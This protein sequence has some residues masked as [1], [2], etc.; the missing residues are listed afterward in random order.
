MA[1]HVIK[2]DL[3]DPFSLSAAERETMRL[4]REFDRKVDEFVREIASIGAQAAA[5]AYGG[6]VGVSIEGIG[7]GF[8]ICADGQQ[9]VFIE[10]GAGSAVNTG[11]MFA[12]QMPFEV[13]QG[14]YSDSKNPPGPYAKSGYRFWKFGGNLY[15]EIVPANGMENAH[16]AMM[17]DMRN[18]AMR[19]FG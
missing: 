14:S 12:G 4:A 13:R 15:T 8:S 16:K 5:G 18:V 3:L 9:V 19:V 6:R 1:D 2:I 7:N 17:Q 10:F 11:N